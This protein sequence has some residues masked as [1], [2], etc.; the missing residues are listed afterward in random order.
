MWISKQILLTDWHA[1]RIVRLV[2]AGIVAVTAFQ[3][4]NPGLGLLSA[5]LLIQVITNT[6]CSSSGCGISNRKQIRDK[7]ETIDFTEIKPTT[8]E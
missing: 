8:K 1:M 4:K 6:G 5:F 2:F 7:D 3:D